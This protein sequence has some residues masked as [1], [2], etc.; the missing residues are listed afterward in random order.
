MIKYF[1]IFLFISC[2]VHAAPLVSVG[3]VLHPS[4]GR[5]SA[6]LDPLP[7]PNNDGNSWTLNTITFRNSSVS[8]VLQVQD[9]AGNNIVYVM[10]GHQVILSSFAPELLDAAPSFQLYAYDSS[11]SSIAYANNLYWPNSGEICEFDDPFNNPSQSSASSFAFYA[12]GD[13]DEIPVHSFDL[14]Y[15]DSWAAGVGFGLLLLAFGWKMKM[16]KYLTSTD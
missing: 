10:A 4:G 16:F 5:T 6:Y 13:A 15:T 11:G 14:D 9:W 8:D 3:T 12:L 2:G 7:G 1:S